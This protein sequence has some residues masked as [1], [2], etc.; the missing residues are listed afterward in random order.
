MTQK[1]TPAGGVVTP[2]VAIGGLEPLIDIEEL[3]QYLG[4][5]VVTIYRWRVEGNGPCAVKIGRHLKFTLSDVQTWLASVRE[6]TP[7]AGSKA[8]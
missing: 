7:G 6:S 3:S 2:H 8:R 4:V 5:P 1:Q